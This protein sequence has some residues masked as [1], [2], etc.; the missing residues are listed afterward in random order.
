MTTIAISLRAGKTPSPL[1]LVSPLLHSHAIS[2]LRSVLTDAVVACMWRWR[3]NELICLMSL[4]R[5]RRASMRSALV[6]PFQ[7]RFRLNAAQRHQHA[8]TICQ[9]SM[10]AVVGAC[11]FIFFCVLVKRKNKTTR[12]SLTVCAESLTAHDVGKIETTV[13]RWCVTARMQPGVRWHVLSLQ[14]KIARRR[15]PW[16]GSTSAT[17]WTCRH[18]AGN[19]FSVCGQ[20]VPG[21]CFLFLQMSFKNVV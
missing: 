6:D 11:P 18:L 1:D 15:K 19:G 13:V 21:M 5:N 16:S 3:N 8:F 9:R 10:H 20:V 2:F 14:S 4:A 7:E 17:R 12:R